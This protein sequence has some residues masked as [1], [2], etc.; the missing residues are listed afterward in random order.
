MNSIITVVIFLLS[1]GLDSNIEQFPGTSGCICGT[2]LLDSTWDRNIYLS[3]I[4][5]FE[6]K[7]AVSNNMIIGNSKVDSLGK[8]SISLNE[9]PSGW[10]LLRLNVV[11]KG[12]PPASLVIGSKDE[13]YCFIIA[14]RF[15]EIELH[16]SS[17]KPIFGNISIS[18]APY[19]NTF[20]YITQLSEYPNSFNVDNA[21]VE[22]EFVEEVISEKLKTIADTCT[23]PLVSLFAV[24]QTEFQEDYYKDPAFYKTYLS[25]WR[26]NNSPYFNSLKRQIPVSEKPKWYYILIIVSIAVFISAAI[27]ARDR[28]RRKIN[29]LSIQERRIFELLQKGASNQEISDEYNIELSTVKSHI[30]SIFSKLHIKSRK[31]AINLK[32]KRILFVLSLIFIINNSWAHTIKIE[33]VFIEAIT[34]Y[35]S[36]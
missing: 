29:T 35:I 27:L 1:V 7:F 3:Y 19:M 33:K 5:T 17:G 32:V 4:E 16:N 20:E 15:S 24:Y 12:V 34:D 14:N 9:L 26:N 31:E 6:E 18:G 22:K 8:F 13:N 10:S 23:N 30:S 36:Y 21:L 11:K 25:K 2:L 28:K